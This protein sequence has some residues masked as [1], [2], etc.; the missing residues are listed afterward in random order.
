MDKKG[1]TLVELLAALVLFAI[2]TALVSTILTTIIRANKDIQISTQANSIGNYL[3]IVLESE[4]SEFEPDTSIPPSCTETTCILNSSFRYVLIDNVVTLNQD[5]IQLSITEELNGIR[6]LL[7]NLT[8]STIITNQYYDVEYFDLNLLFT[9]S[10]L[11][12]KLRVQITIEL[13]DENLK[14]HFFIASH[15]FDLPE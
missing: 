1:I 4:L 13:I 11:S 5:Y 9:S 14:S 3:I 7:E 8:T 12:N 15:I 6:V 10:I 2:L